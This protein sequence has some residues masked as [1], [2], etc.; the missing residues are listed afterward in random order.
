MICH[1]M[2]KGGRRG[3]GGYY[4]KMLCQVHP[5]TRTSSDMLP[6]LSTK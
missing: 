5:S 3:D 6:I 1:A 2:R 4:I